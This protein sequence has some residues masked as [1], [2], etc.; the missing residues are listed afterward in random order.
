[1]ASNLFWREFTRDGTPDL[2][3][4]ADAQFLSTN[5]VDFFGKWLQ[6]GQNSTTDTMDALTR[7][8]FG[9]LLR[10]AHICPPS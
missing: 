3:H 1:M 8:F 10:S 5:F 2:D 6:E 9:M 4:L 7:V